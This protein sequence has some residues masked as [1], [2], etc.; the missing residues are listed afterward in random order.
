MPLQL[1]VTPKPGAKPPSRHWKQQADCL[2]FLWMADTGCIGC[3]A[4]KPGV[5]ADLIARSLQAAAAGK[6]G[7]KGRRP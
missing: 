1:T 6:L 7:P 3:G 2:I 4:G 5:L